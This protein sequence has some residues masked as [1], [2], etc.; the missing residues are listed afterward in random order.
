MHSLTEFVK[1]PF[2]LHLDNDV[3]E[4]SSLYKELSRIVERKTREGELETFKVSPNQVYE[5]GWWDVHRG[6]FST[7]REWRYFI[8]VTESNFLPPNKD[9]NDVI[10]TQSQVY[11]PE[12]FGW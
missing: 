6:T 2:S 11:A 9:L 12:E 1:S 10:R 4:S 5:F 7:G 3:Y 8:R